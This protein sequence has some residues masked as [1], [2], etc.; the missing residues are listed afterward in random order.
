MNGV[1][2][3]VKNGSTVPL[4]FEIF[5]GQTELTDTSNIEYLKY[6]P[7][8]CNAT[9]PTD[10]IETLA[11]GGTI[12]RYDLTG[13]QFIYNWKTPNLLGCF[14]VTMKTIDGSSLTAYFKLK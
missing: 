7:V 4:K 1:F 2:N 14:S 9:A 11:T 10:T 13:G 5:A 6:G 8:A 3:I 12:L